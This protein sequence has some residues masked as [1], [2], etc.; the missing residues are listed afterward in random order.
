[1]A[2]NKLPD[3]LGRRH[4]IEREL[5]SAQSLK[6]AE[7]YIEEGRAVEAIEFLRKADAT[8]ALAKLRDESLEVGDVFLLKAVA[9]ATGEPPSCDEW[10][11]LATAA[12][13]LW[14]VETGLLGGLI[15]EPNLGSE[16][17]KRGAVVRSRPD[18]ALALLLRDI[19][20]NALESGGV[21]NSLITQSGDRAR[22]EVQND[23]QA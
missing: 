5:A 23:S 4:L 22:E 10:Q 13:R 9:A 7:A 16:Q 21:E 2:K 8:E 12:E 1:M 17:R 20:A 18:S 3:P 19:A 11:K 6:I 15:F 14:G